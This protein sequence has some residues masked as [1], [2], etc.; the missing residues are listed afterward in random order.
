MVCESATT[1]TTQGHR[2]HGEDGQDTG[3]GN[4][5]ATPGSALVF[6][7]VVIALFVGL[8]ILVGD[9][10][11]PGLMALQVG[12]ILFPALGYA[13]WARF[14]LE[15]DLLVVRPGARALVGA[16]LAGAGMWFMLVST[17]LWAQSQIIVP[18]AAFL[19]QRDALFMSATGPWEWALVWLAAAF[20]P[21]MCEEVF[22]RG[23]LLRSLRPKLGDRRSVLAVAALFALFHMNIY[24]LIVTFLLGCILGWLLVRTGSLW[25]PILFHLMNNTAILAAAGLDGE[26]LP[27]SLSV[28]FAVLAVG[29]IV[30]VA[31]SPA[32]SR[33]RPPLGED[34]LGACAVAATPVGGGGSGGGSS[35]TRGDGTC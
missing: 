24:Q 33:P 11:L 13:A 29:G 6:F 14:S 4:H 30:V 8:G 9:F 15:E 22:F 26:E 16:V 18:P 27:W 23:V 35:G 25:V 20:T 3:G 1:N 19:E 17:V 21:A 2:R 34:A 5:R 31:G 12:A 10:G 32:A 7:V 28:V